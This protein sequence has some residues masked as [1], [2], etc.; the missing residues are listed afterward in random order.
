MSTT[1]SPVAP[2]DAR[3]AATAGNTHVVRH[4]ETLSSIAA[5]L[6]VSVQALIG[7]N[8]QVHNPNVIYPGDRIE[9]PGGGD[10]GDAAPVGATGG[11]R[12]A[13]MSLSQQGLDL[14]KGFE[15]LRL[16]AYQDSVG[17]WTI[18]YGH[19]AGVRPGD[20]ITQAQAE[21]YLRQDTGWAQQAVRDNVKV[22]LTQGQFDALTSFTFNLGAG[23]LKGS[24]LLRE[25]N[26]GHYSAAKSE[27]GKWV[28]AGGRTLDGLVRRRAAEAALFGG[29]A[30]S[31]STPSQP[32]TPPS[33]TPAPAPSAGGYT[34]RSGD[35]L[36]GIAQRHGVS[37]AALIAANPQIANP[38]LIFAGQRIALPGAGSAAQSV[39]VRSGDTLSGIAQRQ[40]VSLASLIAA[41]PQI[42]DPDLIHPG[43]QVRLPGGAAPSRATSPSP[44]GGTPSTPP[45]S[46][47]GTNGTPLFRQGDPAWGGRILGDNNTIAQAG[48]AM[49]ATAMAL[50]KISGKVITPGQLDSWLD[51]NGGYSGDGLNWGRAAQMAGL[52][53]S[54]P[55]WSLGTINAQL[56]AGRPVVIGV[57]YHAGS[58]GGANGTDHWIT[59]TGRSTVNGQTVY[60]AN[61]PATGRQISLHLEGG[62]LA[63]GE[64]NYRST[65]ELVVFSGGR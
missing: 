46:A 55:G 24:T 12:P 2:A 39:T 56:D 17:V 22:P 62:R 34:V 59:V 30:P 40:G 33:T 35:T 36:S 60:H 27:F 19:T 5:R 7:A 29:Q 47:G 28:H 8:P 32:G 23:A 61:D 3:S 10:M 14:I 49:T 11:T 48:C 4:G 16:S 15:G 20:R 42:A 1:I 37:L 9:V 63:G 13:G 18:G 53:A 54:K 21:A 31:G 25:L 38:N 51:K 43:Q 41:N 57:D 58:N 44:S 45:T 6:G 65:G 52:G 26:A 64:R 50:S